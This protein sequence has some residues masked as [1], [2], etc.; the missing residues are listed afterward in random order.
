MN[1]NVKKFL[2]MGID[3]NQAYAL[4]SH[5]IE[6]D[7][8]TWMI[9]CANATG[10]SVRQYAGALLSVMPSLIIRDNLSLVAGRGK[11]PYNDHKRIRRRKR[12]QA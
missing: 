9:A 4:D 8:C 1:E 2:E 5:G 10:Q 6:A 7:K 11:I 12:H 3:D